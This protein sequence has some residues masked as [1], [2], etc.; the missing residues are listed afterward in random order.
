MTAVYPYD[1]ITHTHRTLNNS[2]RFERKGIGR[3]R[4][5]TKSKNKTKIMPVVRILHS[6]MT[7]LHAKTSFILRRQNSPSAEPVRLRQQNKSRL[8]KSNI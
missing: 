1:P 2:R 5:K 8:M 3:N 7:L 6:V 4:K